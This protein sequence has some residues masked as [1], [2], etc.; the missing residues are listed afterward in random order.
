MWGGLPHTRTHRSGMFGMTLELTTAGEQA[1]IW[2]TSE[3]RA[4]V[5]EEEEEEGE[6]AEAPAGRVWRVGACNN[7]KGCSKWR[8]DA[9][10][11]CSTWLLMRALNGSSAHCVM[12]NSVL[13]PGNGQ[14]CTTG[15]SSVCLHSQK[16]SLLT[17]I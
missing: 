16:F 10:Q 3:A 1:S 5:E 8:K 13:I 14:G 7:T 15:V 9:T 12:I 6:E 4:V 11:G 17:S 2:M